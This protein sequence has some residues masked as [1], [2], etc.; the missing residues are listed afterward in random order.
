MTVPLPLRWGTG[1][2]MSPDPSTANPRRSPR[3][4]VRRFARPAAPARERCELCSAEL[5]ADHN[6]LVEPASRQL[7]CACEPCAILFSGREGTKYRRV[8][9]RAEF[10]PDFRMTDV[11]WAGLD[12]PVNLA[13]LVV[14]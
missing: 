2:V 9:R 6:H 10:L 4:A 7:L 11:Q 13:F 5:A 8:P 3:A 12:L 14:S 1:V